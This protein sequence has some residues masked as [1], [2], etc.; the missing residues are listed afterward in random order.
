[1]GSAGVELLRLL[2]PSTRESPKKSLLGKVEK[3]GEDAL[4]VALYSA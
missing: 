4:A 2:P 1:M 3:E